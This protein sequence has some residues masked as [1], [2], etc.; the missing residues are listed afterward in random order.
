MTIVDTLYLIKVSNNYI[1]KH[2]IAGVHKRDAG[3]NIILHSG[4]SIFIDMP[5]DTFMNR[6]G[7]LTNIV[8]YNLD[9]EKMQC[10][11]PYSISPAPLKVDEVTSS[12]NE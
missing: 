9:E 12:T 8:L 5:V 3:T 1:A 11:Q 10:T 7:S 6:L 2:D 4:V